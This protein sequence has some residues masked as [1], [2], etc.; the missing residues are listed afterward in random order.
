MPISDFL[1]QEFDAE[2]ANTR[3]TLERVPAD[4]GAFAP[5]TKSMKIEHL[6]PHI[7]QLPQFGV[8]VLTTPELDF[9]TSSFTRL[10]FESPAQLV[11]P[12]GMRLPDP[13]CPSPTAP[14][15]IRRVPGLAC[16]SRAAAEM[17]RGPPVPGLATGAPARGPSHRAAANAARQDGMRPRYEENG[18]AGLGR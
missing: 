1:L 16:L 9:A 12:Q 7:A 5:H 14:T 13:V 15:M 11:R 6:A 4:K 8:T 3:K 18:R 2:M 10:P 17:V